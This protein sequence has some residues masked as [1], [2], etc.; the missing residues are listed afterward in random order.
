[1]NLCDTKFRLRP[2]PRIPSLA[3]IALVACYATPALAQVAKVNSVMSSIQ[4]LLIGIS[5]TIITISLLW[6]GFKMAFQHAKWSEVSNVVIG[7]IIA[8]GAPG[9]AV[10]LVNT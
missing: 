3:F 2:S 6:V 10:W 5:V 9:L 4:T 7:A 8:G 1:M